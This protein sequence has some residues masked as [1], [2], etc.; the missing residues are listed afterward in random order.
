HFLPDKPQAEYD[1]V[2]DVKAHG[3]LNLLS[4]IG[5]AELRN[6]VVFSSIAGRFGNGGQTDYSAANDL[7]CKNVAQ[8]NAAGRTRATAIDWTAWSG[9]GMA[10]RGSIPKMMEVAGIDMLPPDQGVPVVRRE[11]T[12]TGSGGEVL[13][14]GALGVLEEERHPTGGLDVEATAEAAGP[15]TGRIA[16]MTLTHGI[17][18]LTELD[19]TT[20]AF[21]YDHRIEGTPVLP[22]VMGL[23]GFAEAARAIAPGYE[24]VA[25]EDVELLAPFKFY[26]DEPRTL[27]LRAHVRDRG[28]GTLVAD[29]ELIGRR[30][31]PGKGEVQTRH[32]TGRARLAR[33][34]V[35]PPSADVPASGTDGV[36][37]DAVYR[38]YF[39]GPAYQVLDRAWR[40]NGHVVGRLAGDLPVDHEP[41]ASPIVFVPRLIELCFQT[42]GVWELGTAGRMALPT[43]VE[44]V[45]RY[46]GADAPGALW[47]VVSPRDGGDGVDAEVV[48]EAGTVRVRLEGYRTIELPGGVDAGALAPIRTAMGAG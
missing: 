1:L 2:F 44:R 25:L 39:H 37:H 11:L 21:L 38:V 18:V 28:D 29:C 13:V 41:S 20:Q 35:E 17:R 47:A 45:V 3:W 6:A 24:V 23:E 30:T 27:E 4:A 40:D 31:L 36:G 26:R 7:L 9:I 42:A 19:P 46:A 43:R 8:L 5:D 12:K 32:F 34:P 15:M 22:G 48:D 33:D 16:G 10:S 14:A